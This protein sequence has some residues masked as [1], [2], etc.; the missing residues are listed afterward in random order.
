MNAYIIP[1]MTRPVEKAC[2]TMQITKEEFFSR[3]RRSDA[4]MARVFVAWFYDELGL[5]I[6]E[7]G[8]RLERSRSNVYNLLKSAKNRPLSDPFFK[9]QF[10]YFKKNLNLI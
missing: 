3:T 4:V 2:F 6:R 8:E 7:I 5:S 1:G 10:E 9:Q